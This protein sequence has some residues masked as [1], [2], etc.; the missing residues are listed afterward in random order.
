[1]KSLTLQPAVPSPGL[2]LA[3]VALLLRSFPAPFHERAISLITNFLARGQAFTLEALEGHR[4]RL[5]I[6]DTG[7]TLSFVVRNACL[8]PGPGLEEG[9][10]VRIG[11]RLA[12]LLALA[13]R[14]EDPDTLFFDRR[15][16]LEGD[17]A[18]G[19][20]FKNFL[21]GIEFDVEAHAGAV[22]GPRVAGPLFAIARRSGLESTLRRLARRIG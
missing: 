11:G 1:M 2:P 3:P 16:T 21:D 8:T 20:L 7:Q 18:A 22:L 5:H 4:V 14:S 10:D 12:D 6:S 17:T 9:Y 15:L 19:L 13:T